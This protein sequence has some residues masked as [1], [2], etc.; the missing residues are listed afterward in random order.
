MFYIV[1]L[2]QDFQWHLKIV[3]AMMPEYLIFAGVIPYLL[4]KNETFYLLKFGIFLLYC[5]LLY[6]RLYI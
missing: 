6:T 5:I 4:W 2:D 3:I 1:D